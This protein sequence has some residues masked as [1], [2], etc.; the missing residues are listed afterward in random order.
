[1]PA[2]K[3]QSGVRGSN[4]GD[5]GVADK[6]NE[7]RFEDRAGAEQIY[8]HAQ[9]D[10][11]RVVVNNDDLTVEQ[12][13]RTVDVKQGNLQV[14]VDMGDYSTVVKTGNHST[15]VSTGDHSTKVKTGNHSTELSLGNHSTKLSLGNHELKMDAGASTVEALQSITLK[16]GAN[17]V[18]IDQTG[19]S[20]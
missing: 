12:G 11:R 18:T 14:A 13:D 5:P 4:W 7:L 8:L 19:V 15:E 2:N 10:F 20:I 17:S 9:K 3:T 6:S 16:V 1:V